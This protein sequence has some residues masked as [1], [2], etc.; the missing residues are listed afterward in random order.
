VFRAASALII[1]ECLFS[2]YDDIRHLAFETYIVVQGVDRLLIISTG[3]MLMWV[4]ASH[5]RILISKL[6]E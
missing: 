5:K 4:Y 2:I 1:I 3:I 6:T